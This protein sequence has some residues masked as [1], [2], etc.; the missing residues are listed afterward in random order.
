[1]L[2][3]NPAEGNG[4]TVMV[5]VATS[6]HP[7]KKLVRVTVYVPAVKKDFVGFSKVEVD[8]SPNF[9][10]TEVGKGSE[11]LVK[12]T[13]VFSQTVSGLVNDASTDPTVTRFFL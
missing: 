9:Q 6:L 12:I 7:L 10:S 8:P 3:V 13:E 4:N 2:V 5:W 11:V 1:M